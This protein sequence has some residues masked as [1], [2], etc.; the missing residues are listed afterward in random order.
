[1]ENIPVLIQEVDMKKIFIIA[2]IFNL[3]L[4]SSCHPVRI[5]GPYKGRIIDADTRQPIEGVVVLG[6]WYK[7]YAIGAT[8]GSEFYDA[9]ETVTDKNGDFKIKGKG[10]LL[11][12]FVGP[13]DL[14]IFKAGYKYVRGG[15]E[16]GIGYFDDIR[17]NGKTGI[18]PLK[19]LTMEERKK[20]HG[21]PDPPSQ[22]PLKKVILM[23]REIDKDDK[24]R[25]LRARGIWN[26]ERY[27]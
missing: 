23:L 14:T 1:M 18:I 3:F 21:P 15:W 22:A 8:G 19:K 2:F 27:E 13:V 12:S 5:D 4:L 17:W 11:F 26:G 24:E 10:L 16:H 7:E 6:V 9:E 20:S 25:G